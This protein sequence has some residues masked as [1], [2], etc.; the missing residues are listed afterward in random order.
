MRKYLNEL[1]E[2]YQIWDQFDFEEALNS[3]TDMNE[4][5]CA[6]ADKF[7]NDP[8]LPYEWDGDIFN[9][10][11]MDEFV[12]Y[13]RQRYPQFHINEITTYNIWR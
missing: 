11:T 1:E 3:Y 10:C 6:V 8:Y 5:M 13:L 9:W 2:M 7:Y 4:L 12:D